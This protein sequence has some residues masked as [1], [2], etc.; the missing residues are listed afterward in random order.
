[1]LSCDRFG[2]AK[3]TWSAD[4]IR[5]ERRENVRKFVLRNC[6]HH[7]HPVRERPILFAG[8]HF[9]NLGV[10]GHDIWVICDPQE[11]A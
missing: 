7:E 4:L 5:L 3:I 8:I 2:N 10:D 1:M 11:N 9:R 6:S